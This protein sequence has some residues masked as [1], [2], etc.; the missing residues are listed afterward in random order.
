MKG[1]IDRK[2]KKR[3]KGRK[4]GNGARKNHGTIWKREKKDREE[5]MKK[6]E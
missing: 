5:K 6:S 2:E 4:K 3:M 1:Q